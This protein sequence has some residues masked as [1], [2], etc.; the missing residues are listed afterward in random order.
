M[1]AVM[2]RETPKVAARRFAAV[3][4]RHFFNRKHKGVFAWQYPVVGALLLAMV[5]WGT[6]PRLL[7]LPKVEG[8]VT[9]DQV[10]AVVGQRCIACHSPTPT[11]PGIAQPPGG[12]LLHTPDVLLRNA[13]R[14]YQQVVVSRIM[15]LANAFLNTKSD[16][17]R[18]PLLASMTSRTYFQDEHGPD[19]AN[20]AVLAAVLKVLLAGI[21]GKPRESLL[22]VL[23]TTIG[24]RMNQDEAKDRQLR[25]A[26]VTSIVDPPKAAVAKMLADAAKADPED[27]RLKRLADA[28][29]H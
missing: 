26:F 5:A 13:Q 2:E 15:P 25:A 20:R 19:A 18:A 7:P 21:S 16:I 29:A 6:A 24:A 4:I 11:F 10:R 27:E 17:V 1:S 9:F 12:V 8:P 3:A 28:W 14:V 23:A 22:T